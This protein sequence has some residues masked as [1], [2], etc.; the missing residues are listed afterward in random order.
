MMAS[1]FFWALVFALDNLL[2]EC[3][4][5]ARIAEM[6]ENTSEFI[7]DEVKPFASP[8]SPSCDDTLRKVGDT[9]SEK[10]QVPEVIVS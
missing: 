4:T 8:S 3:E 10:T 6:A 5:L 7:V 2:Q 9:E 1:C